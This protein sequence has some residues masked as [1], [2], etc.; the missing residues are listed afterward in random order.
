M[1][2]NTRTW[3]AVAVAVEMGQQTRGTV[4]AAAGANLTTKMHW[5]PSWQ[6]YRLSSNRDV[7]ECT[8]CCATGQTVLVGLRST[9][10]AGCGTRARRAGGRRCGRLA[11]R[12]EL[13]E[14]DDPMEWNQANY[15]YDENKL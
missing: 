11:R 14:F 8:R 15:T 13:A 5:T 2:A 7:G 6:R 3:A 10:H 9:V 4:R 1:Y 12:A